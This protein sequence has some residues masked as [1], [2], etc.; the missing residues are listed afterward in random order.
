M[1]TPSPVTKRLHHW[2]PPSENE[3]QHSQKL[4]RKD[5]VSQPTRIRSVI[6]IFGK[7][8]GKG[9][10][11]AS[12][13]YSR[14]FRAEPSAEPMPK[15]T[16]IYIA[17]G[18]TA[19]VLSSF[20]AYRLGVRQAAAEAERRGGMNTPRGACIAITEASLH[21]GENTCI[22]GRVLRVFTSR[23][24]STFLDFC[25]DYHNCP[26]SSVIFAS[27]RSRF[28]NLAT[29]EG[30]KVEISGEITTYNGRAEIV[31]RDPKQIRVPE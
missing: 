29:L 13:R 23:S 11:G 30:R 2:T 9:M 12:T 25:T 4:V 18:I 27:D 28:G 17:A 19:I 1:G 16:G 15:K 31:I 7:R 6:L 5:G 10:V 24:G 8:T 21:T 26:F 22:E 14:R 20:L 3:K